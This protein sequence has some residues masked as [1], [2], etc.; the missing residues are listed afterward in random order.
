MSG[1]KDVFLFSI[2]NKAHVHYT[3]IMNSGY[4]EH[5]LMAPMSFF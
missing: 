2:L 4:N 1:Y 5:V 3:F